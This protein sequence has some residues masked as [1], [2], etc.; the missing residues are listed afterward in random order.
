MN[1]FVSNPVDVPEMSTDDASSKLS[2]DA[3]AA[4]GDL[5]GTIDGIASAASPKK[6]TRSV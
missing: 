5:P 4:P 6:K 1:D 2:E 3:A